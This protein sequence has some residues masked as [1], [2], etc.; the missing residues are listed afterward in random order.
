MKDTDNYQRGV[1]R[2][3]QWQADGRPSADIL[4]YPVAWRKV[5]S[6]VGP[7]IKGNF[8]DPNPWR[9]TVNKRSYL[10]GHWSRISIEPGNRSRLICDQGTLSDTTQACGYL[11][12]DSYLSPNYDRAVERLNE[13]VRG[14]LDLSV[15]LGETGQTAKMLN[16]VDRFKVGYAGMVASYHREV[17]RGVR[18]AHNLKLLDRRLRKWQK[19]TVSRYR[20]HYRPVPINKGVVSRVSS[21]GAN[22]WLEF[23]Y[24]WSPLI[25][26]IRGVAE[27]VL[28]FSRNRNWVKASS[29]LRSEEREQAEVILDGISMPGEI[30]T[31]VVVKTRFKIFLDPSFDNNLAKWTS[32]NPASIAWELT[33]YSFVV[34]WFLDIGSYIRGLETAFLY[35]NQFQSGYCSELITYTRRFSSVGARRIPGVESQV[36]R[37]VETLRHTNFSRRLLISYPA[38][39]V[40]SFKVD[41]GASRLISAA[42]L[43][44]QLLKK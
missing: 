30:V 2:V 13:K 32:L 5:V 31:D 24:G 21:L 37:A 39:H 38:P 3:Q 36:W 14:N 40:P 15:A 19:T 9:Y 44:R 23:T 7:L 8:K 12:D 18:D 1:K 35:G 17:M 33:P 25:S 41:L 20:D 6:N 22:G 10:E 11:Q 42:S 16:L 28:G 4:D 27:N 34:D 43:L 29:T 26:D